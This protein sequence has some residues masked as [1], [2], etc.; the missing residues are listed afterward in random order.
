MLSGQLRF[1]S[2][3]LPCIIKANPMKTTDSTIFINQ[4]F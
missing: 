4:A 2:Y 3:F 1:I